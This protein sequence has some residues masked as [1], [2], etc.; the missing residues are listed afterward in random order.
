MVTY[1]DGEMIGAWLGL[2]R[3]IVW[4]AVPP[5]DRLGCRDLV[6]D[7]SELM[8]IARDDPAYVTAAAAEAEFWQRPHPFGLESLEM[9]GREGDIDT[10]VNRMYTR[11]PRL[12]WEETI[13]RYGDFRRGLVLGTSA[14]TPEARILA[15]NPRLRLTFVDISEGPLSRR[16][17]ALGPRFPGRVD[18]RVADLNFAE[19]DAGAY[20]LIVSSSSIH[21]VTNLEYCA[22]QIARAL[23]PGGFFFLQDY[24]GEPRFAFTEEKKRIFETIVVRDAARTGRAVT[25]HWRDAT[26]LSPF[27]GVRSDEILPV[28]S[29]WLDEVTVKPAGTLT[30]CMMRS[31][32][33]GTAPPRP[34]IPA[35]L[36]Q[37][38]M[39]RVRRALRTGTSSPRISPALLAELAL[40]GETLTAA[41]VLLPATAFAIY[42]R[43]A[44]N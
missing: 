6:S 39:R 23:A 8:R 36:R 44:T 33:E 11:D 14:L 13:C 30:A 20:D 29:R 12:H 16:V 25:V 15:T 7:L 18:I 32:V 2:A 19:F 3:R 35:R 41:G 27:C 4:R 9:T 26:D 10:Y 42:Q 17:D 22:A 21:H 43:P 34:N 24:V 38:A 28:F 5:T 37:Y 1:G 31:N 40:V